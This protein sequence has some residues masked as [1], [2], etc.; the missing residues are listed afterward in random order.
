M[1]S[2]AA[3][4]IKLGGSLLDWPE[5]VGQFRRWLALQPPAAGVII[6][7][8][9]AI[10]ERIRALD[11]ARSMSSE[12][13]HWLA[14]RAMCLTAA[15]AAERLSEATLIRSIGQLDRSAEALQILDVEQL[16]RDEQGT[17]GAMPCN[18][19]VT[20][21]SIAARVASR[22]KAGEL[23]LLKSALPADPATH[24]SLAQ[25]GY[26]DAY[27]PQAARRLAVRLVNLRD[28]R[29]AQVTLHP[30]YIES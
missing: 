29:F 10:V 23:V 2:P 1:T 13:A 21:D 11:G 30:Q 12:T 8:G 3:R 27:F 25:V 14:V 28:P 24:E 22:V 17:A 5:W 4:V 6:T 15:S 18:W 16:L 19:S 20:S 7:G 26:V 9:G